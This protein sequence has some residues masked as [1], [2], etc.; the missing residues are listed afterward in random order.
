M[1]SDLPCADG[2][3]DKYEGRMCIFAGS[4]CEW[5]KE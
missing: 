2:R 3:T 4:P 1:I 5:K